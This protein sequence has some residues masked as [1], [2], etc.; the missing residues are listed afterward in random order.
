MQG[1]ADC[2]FEEQDG[3][4]LV[5]YKTDRVSNQ[6]EL[7]DRYKNQVA[8]YRYAVSKTLDKPVKEAV[9]YSFYLQKVCFYNFL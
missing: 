8:F 4:V 6:Q 2:V 3:L 7:L 5:D 9:L 1:I